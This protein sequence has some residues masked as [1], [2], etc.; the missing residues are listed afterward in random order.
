MTIKGVVSAP[1]KVIISGEHSA[2]YGHPVLL[3]ALN[4]RVQCTFYAEI[5][6]KTLFSIR[7]YTGN[8]IYSS[9]N[10]L[11]SFKNEAKLFSYLLSK[12][13]SP[14]SIVSLQIEL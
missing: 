1:G 9:T 10:D 4:K 2:V 11:D 13:S 6:E 3:M 12:F 8:Q 5:A 7:D 14:T